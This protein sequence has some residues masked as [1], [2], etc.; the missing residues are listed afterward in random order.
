MK[1]LGLSLMG[2]ILVIYWSPLQNV[3]QTESLSISDLF[4]LTVIA[5]SVLITSELLK[6]Y[7]RNVHIKLTET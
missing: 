6:H 5:S 1:I 4:L 3:F 7:K 2:Q